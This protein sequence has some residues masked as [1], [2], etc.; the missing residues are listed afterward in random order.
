MHAEKNGPNQEVV[1]EESGKYLS[2]CLPPPHTKLNGL[3]LKA[4]TLVSPPYN[5]NHNNN[6]LYLKKVLQIE[7]LPSVNFRNRLIVVNN[8]L[9]SINRIDN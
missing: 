3:V 1:N 9:I 7:L 2:G 4:C 8:R 5:N 6:K